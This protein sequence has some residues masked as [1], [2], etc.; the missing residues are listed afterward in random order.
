MAVVGVSVIGG[1][2]TA[3]EEL[4]SI[5]KMVYSDVACFYYVQRT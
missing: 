4:I 2:K 1:I 5:N 3:A